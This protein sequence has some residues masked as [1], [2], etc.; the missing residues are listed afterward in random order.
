MK[1]SY[2]S[3]LLR[4]WNNE[5]SNYTNWQASLEEVSTHELKTF[6]NLD[7]LFLYLRSII[8]LLNQQNEERK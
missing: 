1:I 6:N 2:Q 8:E 5:P 4:I 3:F 7:E